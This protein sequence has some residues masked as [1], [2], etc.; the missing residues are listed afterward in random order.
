MKN[1]RDIYI[2]QMGEVGGR[3][4]GG[5]GGVGGE[6]ELM[7]MD[8]YSCLLGVIILLCNSPVTLLFH[9]R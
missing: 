3:G 5:G 7:L 2:F 1:R 4:G 6:N 9:H 8:K